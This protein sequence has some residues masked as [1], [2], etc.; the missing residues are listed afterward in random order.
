V[1][2]GISRC[3]KTE[4]EIEND[5]T[6]IVGFL[7]PMMSGFQDE[8]VV[9]HREDTSNSWF[10]YFTSLAIVPDPNDPHDIVEI[11]QLLD[12]D[13]GEEIDSV[14]FEVHTQTTER[15]QWNCQCEKRTR[16][17]EGRKLTC[18][19]SHDQLSSSQLCKCSLLKLHIL[20]IL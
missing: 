13:D 9:K 12:F 6:P 4:G 17:F 14:P 18:C 7:I 1:V 10:T 16:D 2:K 15:K 8:L 19:S 5:N 11:L 3:S 20:H